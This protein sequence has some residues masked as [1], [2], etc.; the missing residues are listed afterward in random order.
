MF[1]ALR[2]VTDFYGLIFVFTKDRIKI[3][4]DRNNP[5]TS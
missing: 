2:I 5:F 3:D 4:C 1:R